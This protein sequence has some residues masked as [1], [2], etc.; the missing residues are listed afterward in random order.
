VSS[1]PPDLRNRLERLIRTCAREV[2]GLLQVERRLF[3]ERLDTEKMLTLDQRPDL[4]DRIE[5][6]AARFGR[7]QDNL[8]GKLLPTYFSASGEPPR[9]MADML[10]RAERVGLLRSSDEWLDA[11]RLRNLLVHEYLEDKADLVLH[12]TR[13]RSAIPLLTDTFESTRAAVARLLQGPTQ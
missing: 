9:L 7:L 13:A 11:R 8:A 6:F 2:D 12:L 4:Q 1:V 5:S 10:D 3:A